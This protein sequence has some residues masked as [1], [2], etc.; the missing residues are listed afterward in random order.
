M[1]EE[2]GSMLAEVKRICMSPSHLFRGICLRNSNCADVCKTEGFPDG[3]CKGFLRR[4]FCI[5]PC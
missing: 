4:C 5:K 1:D 2:F 3:K